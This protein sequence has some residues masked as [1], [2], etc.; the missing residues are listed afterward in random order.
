MININILIIIIPF[1]YIIIFYYPWHSYHV[2]KQTVHI[3]EIIYLV[4]KSISEYSNITRK[5]SAKKMPSEINF[6]DHAK[7]FGAHKSNKNI[8]CSQENSRLE[9]GLWHMHIFV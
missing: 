7:L 1:R 5:T 9:I 8:D 2:N 3:L 4:S 6:H